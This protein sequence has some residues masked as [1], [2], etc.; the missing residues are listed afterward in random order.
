MVKPITYTFQILI[1]EIFF[2]DEKMETQVLDAYNQAVEFFERKNFSS[3]QGILLNIVDNNQ[4]DFDAFHLLGIIKLNLGELAEA[5]KYFEK[6]IGLF[7]PHL[8]AHYNLGLCYQS[9]KNYGA[10]R[11]HYERAIELEPNYADAINNLGVV[12]INLKHYDEAEKKFSLAILLQPDNSKAYNNRGNL[13]FNQERFDLAKRDYQ[14]ALKY[15]PESPEFLFNLGSCF[16]QQKKFEEALDYFSKAIEINPGYT[17]AY[18]NIGLSLYKLHRYEEAEVYFRKALEGNHGDAQT[19][20][21]LASC[22]RDMGEP[23]AAI[24]NYNEVIKI[25]PGYESVLVNIG[26]IYKNLG[27]EKEAEK[28]FEKVSGDKNSKAIAFT[29]LGVMRM[30][31]GFVE[32]AIEYF[33][34]ALKCAQEYPEIHYN[35]SHALLISGN[36]EEGWKE[37]EWRKKRKEFYPR[38]Y[39]KPELITGIEVKGKKILVYDEQGLGDSIQFIRFIPMLKQ[40]GAEII[41]ECNKQLLRIYKNIADQSPLIERDIRNEPSIEHDY[42]IPLLSLPMYF[43]TTLETI[44][45][46]VPYI[47]AEEELS[48]KMSEH[49][50][51][52]NHLNIRL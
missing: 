28:Y 45:S 44:P 31:L 21:N 17:V 22:Y 36:F 32:E 7:E 47:F 38:N 51:S 18:N 12:L 33:N 52:E 37:Y 46:E 16:M 3:A 14:A 26:N 5:I 6:T 27:N 39:S 23:E 13:Y 25:D 4:R 30:G 11:K 43:N 49:I 19:H 34:I 15:E 29:N 50:K 41:L 9:L 48:N 8:F 24:E 20:F 10:A 42:Q 1:K 2:D 35:K 40:I